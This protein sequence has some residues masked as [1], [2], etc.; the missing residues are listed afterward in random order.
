MKLHIL[1]REK[2]TLVLCFSIAL[3]ITLCPLGSIQAASLFKDPKAPL[4]TYVLMANLGLLQNPTN[5]EFVNID[6]INSS[7]QNFDLYQVHLKHSHVGNIRFLMRGA[8]G[9]M[10]TSGNSKRRPTLTIVAGFFTGQDTLHLL[11]SNP[12]NSESVT[13]AF[14][15]PFKIDDI[16]KDPAKFLHLL[17]LT[18]GQ[19]ALMLAWVQE[20]NWS[21][22]SQ[23]AVMG[24]SLGGLFLP[25]SLHMAQQLGAAQ[26][27]TIFVCTG[28]D[29][30]EILRPNLDHQIGQFL[31]QTISETLYQLTSS[32]SPELHAPWIQSHFL[33]IRTAQ[34]QVF[35]EQSSRLLFNNLNTPKHEVVLN[36]PHVMP[37]QKDLIRQIQNA[38]HLWLATDQ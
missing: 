23:S 17:R 15:Y 31:S 30:R 27:K 10:N 16:Q 34:D 36:G 3:F 19:I 12:S 1:F 2:S 35:S 37:D 25:V 13:M 32:L 38:I 14:E 29:L 11:D 20:Q 9:F 22:A 28:G 8:N 33:F 26:R 21:D 6:K 24:V 4:S 7:E 18:P 5:F